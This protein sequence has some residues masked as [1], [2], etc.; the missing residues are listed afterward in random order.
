[1]FGQC[2]VRWPNINPTLGQCL[3]SVGSRSSKHETLSVCCFDDGPASTTLDQ[4]KTILNER[5]LF[6]ERQSCKSYGSSVCYFPTNTRHL[7][8]TWP[9]LSQCS[10]CSASIKSSLARGTCLLGFRR[11]FCLFIHVHVYSQW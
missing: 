6:V 5:I 10:Q 9:T 4:N 2:R 1:M 7:P 11:Y 8:N 3:W